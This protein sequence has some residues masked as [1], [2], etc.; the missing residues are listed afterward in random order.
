MV[1]AGRGAAKDV[2]RAE[3][4]F[5][6][7]CPTVDAGSACADAAKVFREGKLVPK[8]TARAASYMERMC[9]ASGN[10]CMQVADM[11]LDGK[12]VPKDRDRALGLY[13]GMCT[14]GTAAARRPR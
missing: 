1:F 3:E 12:D 14:K 10:G 9:A 13:E 2:A 8:D 5:E 11:Y 7:T 4:L 6:R